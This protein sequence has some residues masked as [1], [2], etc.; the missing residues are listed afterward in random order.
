[1][2]ISENDTDTMYMIAGMDNVAGKPHIYMHD[3]WINLEDAF[4]T[5]TYIDGTPFGIKD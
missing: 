3:F 4:N 2:S 1:M 5:F